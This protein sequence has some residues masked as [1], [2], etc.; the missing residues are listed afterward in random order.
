[1]AKKQGGWRNKPGSPVRGG[2]R[3][4]QE[5]AG[6]T[7]RKD[8]TQERSV[9]R[10]RVKLAAG[11]LVVAGLVV[12]FLVYLMHKPMRT[13]LLAVVVTEYDAPIPPNAWAVEDV[14]RLAELDDEEILKYVRCRWESKEQGLRQLRKQLDAMQP[15]GPGK[16]V[17]VVYLSMHGVL[18]GDSRPCLLPP[19]ASRSDSRQWLPLAELI[20]HLFVAEGERTLPDETKKLLV[21]DANRMDANWDLGLLVNGFADR[22]PA[23]LT[24]AKVPNLTILNSAGSGQIGWAAPELGGSVFGYFFWQGLKGAAD[25]EG[26]G[27]AD[28]IVSLSELHAYLEAHVG[29]WVTENR[30]DRQEPLLVAGDEDWE[31]VYA[32]S[33][34]QTVIP[35]PPEADTGRWEAVAR[36][37]DRHQQL[38]QRIPYR[39]DPLGWEEFQHGL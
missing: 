12:G 11:M 15:G 27:N 28:T 3:P 20:D 9:L 21:L 24:D 34:E 36:L 33:S 2:R 32:Q 4:G 19:G 26:T 37:W 6:W 18:D 22:L 5:G 1:M 25:A 30:F 35:E 7:K 29:Q 39:H 38:K 23:V 8:R 10:H 16:D 31:L 14:E 17:V 13:P